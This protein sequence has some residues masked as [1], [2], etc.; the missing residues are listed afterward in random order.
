MSVRH[1]GVAVLLAVSLAAGGLSTL[2]SVPLPFP[3]P[4][5][6]AATGLLDGVS[7][8]D[9]ANIRA[10]YE[11]MADIVVRD[12]TSKTPVVSTTGDLRNRHEYA[13]SMAFVNTGMVG[14]YP[15][16]GEKLDAHLLESIG[17]TDVPL[18]AALREK[19]ARAFLT[20]K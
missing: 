9:A 17:S 15:G 16:L 19:A 3:P 18:D 4:V 2:K 7:R 5:V 12:G 1:I 13:L 20:V 6:P 8:S 11:A 10:F 14:K